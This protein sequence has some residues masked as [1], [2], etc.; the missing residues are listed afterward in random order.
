MNNRD[1]KI[2][3]K[4]SELRRLAEVRQHLLAKLQ[5]RKDELTA[6]GD[7]ASASL[8]YLQIYEGIHGV[9]LLRMGL[10]PESVQLVEKRCSGVRCV[11]V[12]PAPGLRTSPVTPFL[13]LLSTP[14]IESVASEMEKLV[15][16]LWP[17]VNDILLLRS[18]DQEI[19]RCQ[20]DLQHYEHQVLPLQQTLRRLRVQRRLEKEERYRRS[21]L[22][23][24]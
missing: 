7:E 2:L 13:S 6:M 11:Q 9:E 24:S 1:P 16:M 20:K 22:P 4:T 23:R 19:F 3:A 18:L 14:Q 12:E 21:K 8:A 15:S 17:Y 5:K 10:P